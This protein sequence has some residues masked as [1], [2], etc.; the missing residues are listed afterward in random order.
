M[1][2]VGNEYVD[3]MNYLLPTLTCLLL[4]WA[5]AT[6]Q[7]DLFSIQLEGGLT[8]GLGQTVQLPN[9]REISFAGPNLNAGGALLYTR[10][11]MNWGVETGLGINRQAS[12]YEVRPIG[13]PTGTLPTNQLLPLT[14]TA[15]YLPVR[16]GFGG[17]HFQDR[18]E[19]LTGSAVRNDF[20]YLGL[21]FRQAN[22][23]A[24]PNEVLSRRLQ[25]ALNDRVTVALTLG[26]RTSTGIFP[27]FHFGLEAGLGLNP[28]HGRILFQGQ[29]LQGRFREHHLRGTVS[30]TFMP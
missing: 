10:R 7:Y 27:N 22:Y 9:S 3:G 20:Y 8:T 26:I 17:R 11:I 13:G 23:D 12:D 1:D 2:K 4:S 25:D 15:I 19:Q 6:A 14:R 28:A 29:E 30:Y 18:F 16:V 21:E 5:P 24:R